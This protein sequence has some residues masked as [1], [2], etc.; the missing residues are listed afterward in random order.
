MA[1]VTEY[2]NIAVN[3][4]VVALI[5]Y[6]AKVKT[7]EKF[8]EYLSKLLPHDIEL[9]KQIR[10]ELLSLMLKVG[11]SRVN[12]WQFNNGTRSLSKY[13]YKYTS[14][15]YESH[16]PAY[17]SIKDQFQNLPVE[18]YIDLISAIQ[19]APKYRVDTKNSEVL[20]I[21]SMYSGLGIEYG[22]TYKFNNDDVYKGFISVTFNTIPEDK[23]DIIKEIEMSVVRLNSLIKKTTIKS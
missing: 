3:A 17:P 7:K 15:I 14:I 6:L 9:R 22:I 20:E 21:R 12:L 1:L 16:L 19:N 23:E 8:N 5:A 4:L 10:Y 11:A 2:M 13:S 18:D